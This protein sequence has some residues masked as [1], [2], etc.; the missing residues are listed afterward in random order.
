METIRVRARIIAR[1]AVLAA[2]VSSLAVL[3]GSNIS[4]RAFAAPQ[5]VQEHGPEHSMPVPGQPQP[6]EATTPLAT[7][8]DEAKRNDP[9]IQAAEQAAKAATFVAPQVSALPDPQFTVQQFNV[10]SPRPFAG[11]TNSDFAY[12]GLGASQQFPYP[13]K[14][15]LRGA[16]ADR[17]AD[18]AKAHIEVV[19]QGE[20]E[21]LKTTYFRLAYLQQTLGTLQ[22]NAALLQQVEAQAEARYSTGQGN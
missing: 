16:V 13:G 14:L 1:G 17:D 19:L 8:I 3:V 12:I 6:V 2:A 4:E 15:K 21:T 7:L 20:I 18:T 11:Y 5:R 10:G 22:R 9:T